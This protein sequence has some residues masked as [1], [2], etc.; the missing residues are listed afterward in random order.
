[1]RDITT[2]SVKNFTPE[3][4]AC[5]H[6]GLSRMSARTIW[7]FQAAR[8][9]LNRP[10]Y[11]NSWCRCVEYNALIGG[12]PDSSHRV[13]DDLIC[14]A[15]DVTLSPP[16]DPRPMNS[17]ELYLLLNALREAGFDRFGIRRD[18]IHVDD[19]PDKPPNVI[20]LY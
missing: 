19:H 14:H 16:S 8:D 18:S 3:E 12:T 9:Y 5:R 7:K 11:G 1:M 13:G 20:W 2:W 15:G 4:V 10:I 6:C 17:R